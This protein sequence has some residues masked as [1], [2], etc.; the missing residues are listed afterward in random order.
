MNIT[1]FSFLLVCV[2]FLLVFESVRRGILETK[3]SIIWIAMCVI[4]AILSLSDG[5]LQFIAGVLGVF[6][7]PS[8][9]FL[10]GLICTLVMIFDLTRRI[11]NINAKLVT[12][13]Q[14]YTLFKEKVDNHF[15]DQQVKKGDT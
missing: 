8:I 9:L 11:S 4:L 14:E 7:A 5:L 6:Y 2:L 1:L 15:H 13:T 3:Y 10:F 12:L